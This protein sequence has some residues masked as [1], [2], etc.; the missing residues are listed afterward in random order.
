M[1]TD[2][3]GDKTSI[4]WPFTK[5]E[6]RIRSD[7]SEIEGMSNQWERLLAASSCNKAFGS[8]EWYLAS[9]QVHSSSTPYVVSAGR[10]SE[11][12]CI[13]PLALDRESGVASFPQYANDY[14]DVLVRGDNPLLVADLL[15]YAISPQ[16]PCRQ[17][18][19]SKLKPDSDCLRAAMYT[20][21][22]TG[23]AY[24]YTDIEAYSYAELPSSF[25]HYLTSLGRKLRKNIRRALRAIEANRLVMRELQPD[26]F[27]PVD[28]PEIFLRLFLSRHGGKGLFRQEQAQWFAKKLLPPMF[29]NRNLRVFAMFEEGSM[30]AV[31]LFFVTNNGLLA[32]NAGFLTGKEHWSPGTS[33][34]AFAIKQA[35]SG[36]VRE[37]DFGDGD[38]AYKSNWTNNSYRIG[39]LIA[40]RR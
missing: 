11:M 3:L 35:I 31:L 19:L 18:V 14:N 22:D 37:L 21:D 16:T 32:W 30:I 28:L 10:A 17:L 20:K 6:Y 39:K 27:S 40:G 5:P 13:L 34:Y 8:L 23:I 1:A 2:I 7:L 26:S 25:D 36:G 15:K 12:D 24:Q 29:C 4:A 9:C 38:E 33:L